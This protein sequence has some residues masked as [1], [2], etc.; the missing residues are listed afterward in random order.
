MGKLEMEN[1]KRIIKA[2]I[3][4]Q[5]QA[6]TKSG[7]SLANTYRLNN[8]EISE[9]FNEGF[10]NLNST[11]IKNVER[12]YLLHLENS[13]CSQILRDYQFNV[14]SPTYNGETINLFN[15]L[16]EIK[17]NHSL[18]YTMKQRSLD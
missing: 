5:T 9:L 12:D 6:L 18:T 16:L 2:L 4:S 3:S 8:A 14:N 10:C 1:E 17:P 13:S 11:K 15:R 7:N